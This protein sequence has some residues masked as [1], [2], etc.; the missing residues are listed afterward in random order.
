MPCW[1]GC[2]D[3]GVAVEGGDGVVAHE[4]Q[5]EAVARHDCSL[6]LVFRFA[7]SSLVVKRLPLL[8]S[9]VY[10]SLKPSPVS[11]RLLS[12]LFLSLFRLLSF[13]FFSSHPPPLLLVLSGIY[14]VKGSGGVRIATLSCA[15]GAGSSCPAT[16]PG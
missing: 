3:G 15:W 6:P 1:Y 16:T 9:P 4:Q 8:Y 14:R 2:F 10:F 11:T 5:L 7:F 13:S 12:S